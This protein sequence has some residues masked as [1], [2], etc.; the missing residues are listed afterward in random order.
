MNERLSSGFVNFFQHMMEC[1]ELQPLYMQEAQRVWEKHEHPIELQ[2]TVEQNFVH[3]TEG[4][5]GVP[6]QGGSLMLSSFAT[7]RC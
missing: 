7:E 2:V 1:N 4:K 3:D 5:W 6:V